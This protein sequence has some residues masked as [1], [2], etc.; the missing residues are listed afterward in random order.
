MSRHCG[1]PRCQVSAVPDH[2]SHQ[3]TA[4][5]RKACESRRRSPSRAAAAAAFVSKIRAATLQNLCAM[6]RF[7]S[8]PEHPFIPRTATSGKV[9]RGNSPIRRGRSASVRTGGYIL[10][11]VAA[12]SRRVQPCDPW[13]HSLPGAAYL[14]P[15]TTRGELRVTYRG[16]ASRPCM[17]INPNNSRPLSTRCS[18]VEVGR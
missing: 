16:G 15:R 8:S 6:R 3:F 4:L 11:V 2:R 17:R 13:L 18:S 12:Q 14:S 9:S 10:F 1:T 7:Y 5:K